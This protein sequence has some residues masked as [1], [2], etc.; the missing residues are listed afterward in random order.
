ALYDVAS[1]RLLIFGKNWILMR[2]I[3]LCHLAQ[4]QSDSVVN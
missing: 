4:G 1:H 2:N 3:P